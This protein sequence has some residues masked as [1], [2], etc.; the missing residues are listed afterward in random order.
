MP[1]ETVI[2]TFT[3]EDK[4]GKK[5]NIEPTD[6]F[7]KVS[8]YLNVIFAYH[9]IPVSLVPFCLLLSQ[10]MTFKTNIVYLFK[11]DKI[12]IGEMLG[13]SE[14]RVKK[15]IRQ[16]TQYSIIRQTET[17]GRYEVNPFLFSTGSMVE[18]RE[19]QA[20]FDFQREAF[21]V[22]AEQKHISG[23]TVRKAV[24]NRRDRQIEGQQSLFDDQY[25]GTDAQPK[26]RVTAKKAKNKFNDIIQS[27]YSG[28]S[29]EDLLDN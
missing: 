27:D 15:L 2:S 26:K 9:D 19:L 28:I 18:T 12:E 13:V 5:L 16:C 10:R 3:N 6:E 1:Q 14:D 8:K 22:H 25:L 20:H 17:R 11:Q 4:T 29:E 23:E 7:I 24:A 21:V